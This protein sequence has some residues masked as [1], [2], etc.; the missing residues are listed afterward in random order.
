MSEGEERPHELLLESPEGIARLLKSAAHPARMK[1]LA[2]LAQEARDFS[3]LLRQSN[4]SKN[5]L[6]NHL[7][8]MI[9]NGLVRREGRGRYVLAEDGRELVTGA[10]GVYRGSVRR[11]ENQKDRLRMLYHP[12]YSGGGAMTR[13]LV[14]SV[15]K[16]QPC[17]LSFTGAVAGCLRAL[18]IECDTVDVGGMSGYSFLVNVAKGRT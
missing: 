14:G 2:L 6:V 11:M 10:A 13:K 5:A 17:W 16:Y 7:E 12:G 4:L 9:E 3:A 18:G 1:I 8:M 15:G